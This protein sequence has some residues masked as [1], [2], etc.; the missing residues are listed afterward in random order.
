MSS[1][2]TTWR[3]CCRTVVTD[4]YA[5]TCDASVKHC[6]G[7]LLRG[8]GKIVECP[9]CI[10][11][12]VRSYHFGPIDSVSGLEGN[13]SLSDERALALALSSSATL[14]RTETPQDLEAAA[15]VDICRLLAPGIQTLYAAARCW[16]QKRQ[17]DAVLGFNGRM[18]LTAAVMEAA[19]DEGVR[20]ISVERTWF[21]HGIQLLP[22]ENCLGTRWAHEYAARY[23]DV[24]LTRDQA[25]VAAAQIARRFLRLNRE[26]WRVYNENFIKT[27]W[28]ARG[29]APRVLI[30]PSSRNEFEGH[31][32]WASK[33]GGGAFGALDHFLDRFGL[34]PS[35]CVLRAHPNWAEKIGIVNGDLSRRNYEDWARRRGVTFIPPESNADT[36][37]LLSDCDVAVLNGG[38]TAL[39]AAALGK[40]VVLLGM[41]KYARAGFSLSL[42]TPEEVD[43][44]A[45][46][47]QYSDAA[48]ARRRML[49]FV[50]CQMSRLPQFTKFVRAEEPT[51]Y[52]Y[53][54]GA[55]PSRL[56]RMIVTGQ[57]EP[58]DAEEAADGRH[59]D[60]FIESLAEGEWSELATETARFVPPG[61]VT[62]IDRRLGLRWTG[63][64]RQ[65]FRRGDRG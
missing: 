1:R 53:Y 57:L 31:L 49:R 5:L 16:I 52:R 55:N 25:S 33:W 6:Y 34:D 20:Y 41:A 50:Y 60:D 30:I 59:E 48:S 17:L 36:Y 44:A 19:R 12:G 62:K 10:L 11:G 22:E 65:R 46:L 21:G 37:D 14:R 45:S 43:N 27:S 35:N 47:F 9:R 23:R 32:E 56:E 26:E 15:T 3:S 38:S 58:D 4:T 42:Q 7:A 51:T 29:R 24:P 2:C 61:P 13:S 63:R 18:D 64:L 39:E 40:R 28:P 54:A 8:R